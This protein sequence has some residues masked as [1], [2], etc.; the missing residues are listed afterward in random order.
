MKFLLHTRILYFILFLGVSI[1]A[2]AQTVVRGEIIDGVNR[3]PLIG[4]NAIIKGTTEGTITDYDGSCCCTT[5][6]SPPFYMIFSYV[7]YQDSEVLI[8]AVVEPI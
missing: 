8:E 2:T 7:G 4:A 6:A 1:S 3:E 5:S